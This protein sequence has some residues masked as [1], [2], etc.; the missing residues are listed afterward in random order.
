[1]SFTVAALYQF[2]PFATP[3]AVTGPLR[4][5]CT[6]AGVRGT[7]LV[8]HEGING[9][10]GGTEAGVADVLAAIR[11]LPGCGDLEVKFS[12]AEKMPFL[13]LKVRHKREIVTM[14]MPDVDPLAS[15]GRYVEPQDWNALIADPDVVVV[16]TR[17]AYEVQLGTFR[18]AVD[19]KTN[20]F[21]EFPAWW[22]AKRED[23]E[24]KTVAMF[25]TGGIR[26]EKATS[27][28]LEQGAEDVRHLK[29]GILRYLEQVHEEESL[30]EGE[31]FVFDQRVSVGHGLVEG[32][33]Q[34]C[35]ACRLPLAPEDI[36]RVEYERGV[37]CHQCIE[38]R[39]DEDRARYRQRQTQ[40][41]LAKKRGGQHLG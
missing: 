33:H 5:V 10:I 40:I 1:M 15:V 18:G 21:R 14:G 36:K 20:S 3:G 2:T 9:T 8:A 38:S 13:R 19:P 4:D 39:T 41:D 27:F 17:N 24:G 30:W 11:A 34:L 37:S 31:C 32:P 6:A 12:R 23:L 35:H 16:D 26:C 28:L 29:G 25:C 22:A 7:L